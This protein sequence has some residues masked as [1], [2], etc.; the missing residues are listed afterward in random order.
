V[1]RHLPISVSFIG[2]AFAEPALLALAYAFEQITQVR[3]PP[4][5]LATLD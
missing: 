2:G 4:S 3:V 5:F 1:D